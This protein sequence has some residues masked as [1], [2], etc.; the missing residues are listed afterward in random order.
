MLGKYADKEF[1]SIVDGEL[2]LGD[3]EE[4]DSLDEKPELMQFVKETLGDKIKRARASA[5]SRR[6]PCA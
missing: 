3:E 6:I 4:K 1:R 2:G 5:V